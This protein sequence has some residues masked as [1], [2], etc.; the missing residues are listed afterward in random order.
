MYEMKDLAVKDLIALTLKESTATELLAK[1]P[2]ARELSEATTEEL[3]KVKGLGQSKARQI[4]AGIELGKRLY[5]TPPTELVYIRCPQD[6]FDLLKDM[7]LLDREHFKCINLSTKNC[8]LEI[9]TVSIG[10]LNSSPVH[11]RELFKMPIKRSAAAIIIA[12]NHPSGDPSPSKE[13]L[14]VTKRLVDAGKLLGIELFDHIII[15]NHKYVSLKE[16][17]VI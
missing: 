17:G 1:F 7:Q 4:L 13:D 3:I 14:E 5:A 12:H 10:S 15:G 6:V 11:P 16:K 2:S 8:I 9:D